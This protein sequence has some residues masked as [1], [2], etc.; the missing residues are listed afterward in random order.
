MSALC[1]RARK[2]SIATLCARRIF[3]DAAPWTNLAV[4]ES[5]RPSCVLG[6]VDFPPCILQTDLPFKAGALHL[7]PL[8]LDLAVHWLQLCRPKTKMR[9]SR[10]WVKVGFMRSLD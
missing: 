9:G 3:L 4:P 5:I 6:P 2:P 8:R 10:N 1:S 7:E